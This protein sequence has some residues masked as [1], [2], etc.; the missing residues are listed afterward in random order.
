MS[1]GRPRK[2]A[3][4]DDQD[5]PATTPSRI[6]A[7]HAQQDD[8]DETSSASEASNDEEVQDIL[9][10]EK[11]KKEVD[12]NS[13]TFVKETIGDPYLH[14]NAKPA[15][16]SN[17]KLSQDVDEPF[18]QQSYCAALRVHGQS[19]GAPS[20]TMQDDIE[21]AYES[22]FR[23]WRFELQQG[24]SCLF[25]GYGSKRNLLNIFATRSLSKVGHVIVIN[26]FAP[27][28]GIVDVVNA[29]EEHIPPTETNMSPAKR[30][31]MAIL[32]ALATDKTER[33]AMA[34]CH[35]LRDAQIP[36]YLVIHNI[37]V[38][39]LTS[40]KSKNILAMLAAQPNL[41]LIASIDHVRG[42][43]LFPTSMAK[44]FPNAEDEVLKSS[45]VA[46]GFSFIHHHTPTYMPYTE[47][48]LAAGV[49]SMLFPPTIF[50]SLASMMSAHGSTSARM[51]GVQS[52]L[53]SLNATSTNLF[54]ALAQLQ[55]AAYGALDADS[56]KSL[57]LTGNTA[58]TPA[59]AVKQSVLFVK[60]RDEFVASTETQMQALLAEYRDH[61]I[62]ASSHEAPEAGEA[63]DSDDTV[64]E[65]LWIT[66]GKSALESVVEW[67][68]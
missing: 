26:G 6:Y 37:E 61:F 62:I 19:F 14:G 47:E 13:R 30:T 10:E 15:R 68:G 46:R 49:P 38:P 29:L 7:V 35:R 59:V 28:M 23:L 39:G 2:R 5:T 57:D 31:G 33:R 66:L 60:A 58:K 18:G 42:M 67:M 24:F 54:K 53:A 48:T 63:L 9:A 16:T 21:N 17:H 50:P 41:H 12:R 4:L 3:R 52:V 25:H 40:S 34:F 56:V 8:G 44:S 27:G 65:W 11:R 43:L 22:R 51:Q 1:Q 55:L 20:Q 45:N 32:P 64:S 36:V